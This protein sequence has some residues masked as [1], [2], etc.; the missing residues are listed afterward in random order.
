MDIKNYVNYHILISHSPSNLN[1]DDMNMQKT[2][3]FGGV[4]RTRISSQSLKRAM[5]H[6]DYYKNN[7]GM[8]SDRTRQLGK[9][10]SKYVETLKGKY[11]GSLV[12]S[13]ISLISGETEI[14]ENTQSGAV[15]A[16]T[17]SE[18]EQY[19]LI[20]NELQ[21]K[22]PQQADFEREF[23]EGKKSLY[24]KLNSQNLQQKDFDKKYD[25][26]SKKLEKDL[27]QKYP[28][29][30]DFDKAWDNA[31][32]KKKLLDDKT[33]AKLFREALQNGQ[34]IA[35]SGRMATS[36]IMTIVDA[37]L[38]VAHAITTHTVDTDIDWFTAVDDLNQ[39]TGETG[40]AHLDTTEFSSGV[41]YRYA[42]LN[43]RQLQ[44]NLGDVDREQALDIA[45]HV[46]HMLATV[47][48]SGKQ[49][50]FAAF[51]L[52]DFALV[53]FSDQPISLANAFENPVKSRGNGFM[54]PSINA[55]MEYH[56]TISNAYGLKGDKKAL[57]STKE[58]N[59]EAAMNVEADLS[60]LKEWL[61]KDGN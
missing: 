14:K 6:S 56:K 29:H 3:V 60:K 30:V 27:K 18:V 34:D 47:V 2:A 5:R 20:Y 25:E 26:G 52:A 1:R 28:Q 46:L 43:L 9:L 11:D 44:E 10:T 22:Y 39:E 38:A 53:S 45:A 8:P 40:S 23:E 21:D 55:L 16:W 50:A 35:L 24:N 49:N 57:F 41:F 4:K 13:V 37:S 61:R 42:S 31:T 48:P 12:K 51:N 15:A 36:G 54:E 59:L 17:V 7:I 33:K 32:D 19:C 58:C